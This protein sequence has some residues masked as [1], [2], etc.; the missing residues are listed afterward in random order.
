MGVGGLGRRLGR[1]VVLAILLAHAAPASAEPLADAVFA[2]IAERLSLM[3]SVAAWKRAGGVAVE[4][5]EREAVVLESA[6]AAAAEAGLDP[7]AARPFFA[8][9]IEAAKDIQACWIGRWDAGAAA[10]PEET[11]DLKTEIRPA[12]L[13]LGRGLLESTAAALGQGVAFDEAAAA[14][15]AAAVEIDCLSAPRRDAIYG[16]LGDLRLAE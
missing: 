4:D 7:A 12:L 16:T 10:P 14:D 2:G 11:L 8:A 9:Q 5:L 1:A 13:E 6:T 15:Y 3:K